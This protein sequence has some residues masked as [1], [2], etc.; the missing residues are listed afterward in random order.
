MSLSE[1]MKEHMDAVRNVTDTKQQL[2]ISEAT[3]N[4][5]E[6]TSNSLHW[7]TIDLTDG[8]DPNTWYPVVSSK[9]LSV[10]LTNIVVKK[11]ILDSDAHATTP[12]SVRGDKKIAC[13]LNV[14]ATSSG[15]GELPLY[16]YILANDARFTDGKAPVGFD[17]LM[18]SSLFL[19]WLRGGT[20]YHVGI[21]LP[22]NTWQVKK[23]AF[24]TPNKIEIAPLTS[25][26]TIDLNIARKGGDTVRFVNFLKLGGVIRKH[27]ADLLPSRMEVAA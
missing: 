5:N 4:L 3:A 1:T 25:A 22:G 15:W 23:E 20:N 13:M 18:D 7:S 14:L 17:V 24:T 27:L 2:S 21:S 6:I 9:G 10:Q 19:L 11:S 8:F 16:T 26:P 12:W